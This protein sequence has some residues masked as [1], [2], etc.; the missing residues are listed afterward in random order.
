[1]QTAI[2]VLDVLI[3]VAGLTYMVMGNDEGDADDYYDPDPKRS[4]PRG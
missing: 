1:M 4:L 3:I 2:V